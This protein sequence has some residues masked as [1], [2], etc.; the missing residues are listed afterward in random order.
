MTQAGSTSAS[1]RAP[2]FIWRHLHHPSWYGERRD[3]DGS[4][5][6]LQRDGSWGRVLDPFPTA[7]AVW[8]TLRFETAKPGGYL[9]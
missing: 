3:A 6:Y 1:Y 5:H 2:P 9:H 7:L 4:Y 8:Q